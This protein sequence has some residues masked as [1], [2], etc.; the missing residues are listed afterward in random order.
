[1]TRARMGLALG[2][3]VLGLTA[4]ST[5][6]YAQTGRLKGKVVDAENKPV[7]GA[8]ITMESKEMN[9]KLNTKTD[10]RGEYTQFLAPG[11]YMVTASKGNL[12]ET[13][14]VRVS[15]DE[16]DQNF[17]LRAGGGGGAVSDADRKK[18]EAESA[19][20]KA[21]FSEGVTLSNE[22]KYDEA[23][24]KFNEVFAKA[25]KC[26]ECQ[27][28][29]GAV[30][31]RKK[32]YDAAEAAYKKALEVNASSA[33]AYMGLANVYNAQKK[34][35]QATEAGAQAQKLL[36]AA[37]GGGGAGGAANASAVFN[38]GVIAWNAGKIPDAQKL[39]EQAVA[40]DPKMAEAHYWLGMAMV[41]QGKLP[42]AV[43]S[44]EEYLKLDGSG[45]YAEQAKGMLAAIKK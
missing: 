4:L 24:A 22:G 38:Q 16:K 26:V 14:E 6:G 37:P 39:F 13:F 33:E 34:F 40:A 19:A 30:Y 5:I 9:R 10:K 15:L 21:L 1:M 29:I 17:T 44:F 32:D 11:T 7:E 36:A 25:P 42:E 28:N 20:V 41:N 35:D 8:Q 12:S 2:A 23:V 18:A 27:T 3:F 31:L 43:K 45:Q